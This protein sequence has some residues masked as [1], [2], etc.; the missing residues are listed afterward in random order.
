MLFKLNWIFTQ[1]EETWAQLLHVKFHTTSG[2]RIQYHK[3]SPVWPGI[4]HVEGITKPFIG[5]IIGKGMKIDFWRYSWASDIPL[6]EDIDLPHYLWKKCTAR[7]SDLINADGWNF[8]P[9]ISLAFLAMGINISNIPCNP[10]VEDIQIWKPDVH[11]DFSVKNVVKELSVNSK[12]GNAPSI[13]SCRWNL[14]NIGEVKVCCDGLALG[15]PGPSGIGVVYRDWE[16]RVLGMLSKAVGSPTNCL[17]EVQA[18]VDGE[19]KALHRG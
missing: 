18:I 14:P 11:G 1:R 17:E 13:C 6:R 19:E 15:N 5:W 2:E 4:K 10:C 8:P 9:D 12:M 3:Q 7:V 16:G